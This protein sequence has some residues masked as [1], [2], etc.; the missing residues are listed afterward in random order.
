MDKNSSDDSLS[1]LNG[2]G[3][4]AIHQVLRNAT[5]SMIARNDKT[6]YAIATDGNKWIWFKITH[7]L[8]KDEYLQY[9]NEG[10][11]ILPGTS[12]IFELRIVCIIL[13]F[14]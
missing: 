2:E 7:I 8:E 11:R 9:H 13:F 6:A 3:I 10:S 12:Y 1:K 14:F 4:R 5:E